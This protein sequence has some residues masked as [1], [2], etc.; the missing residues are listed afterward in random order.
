MIA[1]GA[2]CITLHLL[3]NNLIGALSPHRNECAQIAASLINVC[4][5]FTSSLQVLSLSSILFRA[6]KIGFTNLGLD[7]PPPF[8]IP[9]IMFAVCER[10]LAC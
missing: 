7:A 9:P 8:P 3:I 4:I 1:A 2:A 6:R 10:L 5:V